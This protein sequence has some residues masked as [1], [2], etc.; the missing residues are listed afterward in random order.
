MI[1]ETLYNVFFVANTLKCLEIDYNIIIGFIDKKIN[2]N[3]LFSNLICHVWIENNNI[4]DITYNNEK[5][6]IRYFYKNDILETMI[7]NNKT[8]EQYIKLINIFGRDNNYFK[9]MNNNITIE[10]NIKTF[11]QLILTQS[12]LDEIAKYNAFINE[13]NCDNELFIK[14]HKISKLNDLTKMKFEKLLANIIRQNKK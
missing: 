14:K 3:Y 12:L 9:Y 2:N 11:N 1:S 5:N 10:H 4:Y 13:F 7:I 6:N 8:Y